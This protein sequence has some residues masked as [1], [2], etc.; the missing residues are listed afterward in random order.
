MLIDNFFSLQFMTETNKEGFV[1]GRHVSVR[2]RMVRKEFSALHAGVVV[3]G[4]A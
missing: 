4:N 3:K 2:K 1:R